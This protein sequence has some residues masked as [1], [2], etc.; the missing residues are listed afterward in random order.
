MQYYISESYLFQPFLMFVF[1]SCK[2]I[3]YPKELPTA[4]IV[5]VFCNEAPSPILRTIHSVVNR[6]PPQYLHEVVLLDDASDRRK[7]LAVI[8][9]TAL[10]GSV[11]RWWLDC[12]RLLVQSKL[13]HFRVLPRPPPPTSGSQTFAFATKKYNLVLQCTLGSKQAHHVTYW[14]ISMVLKLCLAKGQWVEDQRHC[15]MCEMSWKYFSF[16][17]TFSVKEQLYWRYYYLCSVYLNKLT[18]VTR[19]FLSICC[20]S[21]SADV[22][23]ILT[24]YFSLCYFSVMHVL[25]SKSCSSVFMSILLIQSIFQ[26]HMCHLFSKQIYVYVCRYRLNPTVTW[27]SSLVSDSLHGKNSTSMLKNVILHRHGL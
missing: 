24:F 9:S 14:P 7:L 4:S 23:L 17:I 16:V 21:T 19:T 22:T 8:I 27:Q 2:N 1:F 11:A 15:P 6:T 12:W 26:M 5:I 18:R 10:L 25:T 3:Q 20:I 13:L